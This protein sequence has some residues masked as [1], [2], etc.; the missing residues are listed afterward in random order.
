[1]QITVLA[2]PFRV[3]KLVFVNAASRLLLSP[4]LV[5]AV[6]AH[7]VRVVLEACVLALADDLAVLREE[8]LFVGGAVDALDQK[9]QLGGRRLRALFVRRVR[10]LLSAVKASVGNELLV[11]LAMRALAEPVLLGGDL[12]LEVDEADRV[13]PE[14]GLCEHGVG[15]FFW[16]LIL[17]GIQ[18]KARA[19]FK[20]EER[21]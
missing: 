1:M 4:A 13:D 6:L 3:V 9:H 12:S 20:P 10:F 21:G 17:E 11:G 15:Q 19:R 14:L 5:I 2:H 7:A 18:N 8:V 16:R